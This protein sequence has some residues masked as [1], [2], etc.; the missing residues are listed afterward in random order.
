MHIAVQLHRR[1]SHNATID[2]PYYNAY[3]LAVNHPTV[4]EAL[5]DKAPETLAARAAATTLRI[6][7]G[8]A[9]RC[10]TGRDGASPVARP[11]SRVRRG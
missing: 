9:R 7:G 4:L 11:R 8:G 2:D 3:S 5:D 1:L 6:E 10:E